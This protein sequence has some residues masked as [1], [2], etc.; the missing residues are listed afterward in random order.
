MHGLSLPFHTPKVMSLQFLEWREVGLSLLWL[1][2][3]SKPHQCDQY[4]CCQNTGTDS[5]TS[6]V[7]LH[8]TFHPDPMW[9]L[10]KRSKGQ[11]RASCLPNLEESQLSVTGPVADNPHFVVLP[12]S[13]SYLEFICLGQWCYT[14]PTQ[15]T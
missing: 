7:P 3:S 8:W 13:H 2:V 1:A 10:W 6:L 14:L 11:H 5:L 9:T 15:L 4:L 12:Q